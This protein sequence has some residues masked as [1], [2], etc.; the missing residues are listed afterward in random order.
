MSRKVPKYRKHPNGQG[1]ICTVRL[2]EG[3]PI[4]TAIAS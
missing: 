4:Y 3:R 1:F 2:N